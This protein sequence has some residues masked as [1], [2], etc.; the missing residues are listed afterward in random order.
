MAALTLHRTYSRTNSI[1]VE[2]LSRV[3]SVR[4]TASDQ[5]RSFFT[6]L[7]ADAE[8]DRV[9]RSLQRSLTME[10]SSGFQAMSLRETPLDFAQMSEQHRLN[11]T[12]ASDFECGHA[13]PRVILQFQA[14]LPQ[15][16]SEMS[17]IQYR[18]V[19][20]SQNDTRGQ[21][22]AYRHVHVLNVRLEC[23][24]RFRAELHRACHQCTAIAIEELFYTRRVRR[25]QQSLRLR[26]VHSRD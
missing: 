4:F 6:D 25:L 5:P 20:I 12:P 15:Q 10:R 7:L 13:L 21:P 19:E 26:D 8:A 17:R 18:S 14:A 22:V 3:C 1:V 16:R 23:H 2:R 24:S 11:E 9:A